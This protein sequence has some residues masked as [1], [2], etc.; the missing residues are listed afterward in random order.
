MIV[1]ITLKTLPGMGFVANRLFN[2]RFVLCPTS[3]DA[4]VV[5]RLT[6]LTCV[7]LK[8]FVVNLI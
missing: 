4:R 8:G 1:S 5:S 6:G 3:Q 7:T 2:D